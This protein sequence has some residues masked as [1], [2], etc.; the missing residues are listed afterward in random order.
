MTR[1]LSWRSQ[2]TNR[3][4]F[5]DGRRSA[6]LRWSLAI[7]KGETSVQEAACK[8]GLTVAE[9]EQWMERGLSA[10]ENQLRSKPRDE[11]EQKDERI[12]QLERKIGQMTLDMDIL[13]EAA[14]PYR[15]TVG[16]TSDE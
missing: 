12:R 8:Y 5:S 2:W 1:H 6:A 7:L 10:M 9:V 13:K 3:T 16:R 4:R 14:R 11:D 15:P